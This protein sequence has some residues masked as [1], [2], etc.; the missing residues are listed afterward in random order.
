[1]NNASKK[2]AVVA[3]VGEGLGQAIARRFATDYHVVMFA[4]DLDKLQ[5]YAE[6]LREAGG[7]AGGEATG[8]KVDLRVESEIVEALAR[9]EKEIGPIEVAVYNA[10]AQHRKPLLEIS[11]DAFEKVWRLAAFGAFVFGREAVRHMEPRGKGTILFTGATSSLRGG[12][13]FGAFA[14]AKF[15]TRAVMQSIAREF[16]PKGIH[17]ATV[18]IDGAVDMPAIHRLMPD[19]VKSLPPDGMLST[20]QV[21]ETYY[22]IHRQHRS[23]WTLEA[24]LRPYSEEF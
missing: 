23:A 3:G 4:R 17:A 6:Q 14:A 13:N 15:A 10:G 1:M 20:D 7:E 9:I 16:G 21:A 5:G 8:M 22:Q 19:L 12:A 18:I 2:V 24:D 11:G